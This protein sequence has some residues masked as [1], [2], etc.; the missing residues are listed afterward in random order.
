MMDNILDGK[1]I[2]EKK[3]GLWYDLQ[4][5]SF[6][7]RSIIPYIIFMLVLVIYPVAQ[8]VLVSFQADNTWSIQN[9]RD[10]LSDPLFWV[11]TVNTIIWTVS[12]VVLD[13]LVGLGLALLLN[14]NTKGKMIFRTIILVIPWATPDIVA[15]VAWKWMYNDMYGVLNDIL[16]KLGIIREYLPWLAVPS[17]AKAAV[18]IANLWKGF[19]ISTMFYLAALQTVPKE[20]YEAASMDGANVWQRF[21]KVTIPVIRPYILTTVML[22]I[23]WTINYFPLIFAMTSGGPSNATDTFVTH[24]YRMAFRFLDF[25]HSTVVSNI[26]FIIVLTVAVIYVLSLI[27]KEG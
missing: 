12:C 19:A 11:I 13:L 9:Y 16:M 25:S 5:N 18:I 20:L 4:R 10:V 17:L 26:N 27:R 22:T 23:I 24:S 7:Y 6:A 15:A 2:P 8:N 1:L 14:Q 3:T 21:T